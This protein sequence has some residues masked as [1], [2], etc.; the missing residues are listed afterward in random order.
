MDSLMAVELKS[1][2]EN[3]VKHPLP[4]TLTFDYPTI[5]ALTNYLA[6]EVL[7]LEQPQELR[8]I[9]SNGDEKHAEE[10]AELEQLAPDDVKALLDQEL[11]AI[12]QLIGIT[13]D[14]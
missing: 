12:D 14:D 3:G 13:S 9:A 10:Y 11:A 2:L 8:P 5:E 6:R 7:A 4:A 1:R